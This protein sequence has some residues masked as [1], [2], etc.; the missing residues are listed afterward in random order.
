MYIENLLQALIR[1]F[2]S[3]RSRVQLFV[4]ACEPGGQ[5]LKGICEAEVRT[6]RAKNVDVVF[7]LFRKANWYAKCLELPYALHKNGPFHYAVLPN[8]QPLLFSAAPTLSV[9]HDLTYRVAP[10]HFSRIK[11]FYFGALTRFRMRA[12][13]AFGYISESTKKDLQRYY[14]R[15]G[16]KPLVFLPNGIPSKILETPRPSRESIECKL[17]AK[18]VEL[19]FV[20]RINRLKG[21]DRVQEIVAF[22]DEKAGDLKAPSLIFHIVGKQTSESR[23][24]LSSWHC[25]N[26]ELNVHGHVEDVHLNMLY[27]R[28]GFCLFPS[29]NEGFGLPVIE[30]LWFGCV[31]VLSR[32][33]V[34]EELMG[35]DFSFFVGNDSIGSRFYD[36]ITKLRS[37]LEFR[38]E[39]LDL[40][41]R[42]LDRHRDGYQIAASV[43]ADLCRANG[44][45]QLS[46]NNILDPY[47]SGECRGLPV[48][49]GEEMQRGGSAADL[50]GR[51]TVLAQEARR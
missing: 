45:E 21:F 32:I 12:D 41:E 15:C 48:G 50:D 30:S 14:P 37:D 19:L 13:N 42:A 49:G 18:K 8:M 40:M 7:V 35:G 34:F 51:T 44:H 33:P 1:K 9:L 26:I 22:L 11:K 36:L 27:Q 6:T 39:T 43:V 16:Q 25:R 28:C 24:L 23:Q 46:A 29:R 4:F 5:V 47:G 20:G 38:K 31:P 10:S 17:L 3:N 2:A